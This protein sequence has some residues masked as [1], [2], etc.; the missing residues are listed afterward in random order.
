[1][2][3]APVVLFVY[4]RPEH[5]RRTVEALAANIGATD[6]VLWIFSDAAR[7]EAAREAVSEVRAYVRT[8]VGSGLFREVRISEAETNLGLKASII[9]GVDEAMRA[10]GR[11]IVLEDDLVT[12]PDFLA[13]MNDALDFYEAAPDVGS[14]AGYCPLRRPPQGYHNSVYAVPRSSSHGWATWADRWGAVDW[15]ASRFGEFWRTRSMRRAFDLCG[16][17]RSDRLRREVEQGAQSWSV[18][19]GFS[20]FLNGQLTIVPVVSRV[21]NIGADGSGVHAFD[22]ARL[23][24]D[25]PD[26]PVPY[27]LEHVAP[28]ARVMAMYRRLNSGSRVS[29]VA[30]WMRNNGLGWIERAVRRR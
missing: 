24:D 21:R 16:T 19:F 6:T 3:R 13:F 15:T 11:A 7:N 26:G 27:V 23:N 18:L 12:A 4:N 14:I 22:G 5:T 29:R 25:L 30:R 2:S 10:H 17:D 8:L 20:L 9:T 28:D 1:M